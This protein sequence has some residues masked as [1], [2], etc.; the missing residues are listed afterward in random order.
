ML[1]APVYTILLA[2]QFEPEVTSV[3]LAYVAVELGL[4]LTEWFADQQQWGEFRV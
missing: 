2:T 4:V 1:A 3:D